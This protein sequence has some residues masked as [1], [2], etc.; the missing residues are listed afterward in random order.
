MG[1]AL[2]HQ[3]I[4]QREQVVGHRAKRPH[5]SD[6]RGGTRAWHDGARHH[7]ALRHIQP[8]APLVHDLHRCSLFPSPC[9]R[10]R[11]RGVPERAG[12]PSQA[13]F[14]VRA[15]RVV[16]HGTTR[17]QHSVVPLDTQASLFRGLAAPSY[18]RPSIIPSTT[19][20]PPRVP[21][22]TVGVGRPAM[23]FVLYFRPFR[24][25]DGVYV[26]PCAR[27]WPVHF[28]AFC[29]IGAAIRANCVARCSRL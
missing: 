25:G 22:F 12:R 29:C 13:E 24:T 11:Q 4:R 1:H 8:T 27:C 17:E 19:S 23:M 28:D 3:P 6:Q 20:V 26:A 7:R 5:L 14:A 9:C 2:G 15:S 10:L 21:L 16:P 18:H